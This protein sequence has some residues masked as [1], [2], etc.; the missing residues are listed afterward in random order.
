ML[1]NPQI[2]PTTWT[3]SHM[4][5]LSN[6]QSLPLRT[7]LANA[8][9]A[10]L[11]ANIRL[12]RRLQAKT[13]IEDGKTCLS[14]LRHVKTLDPH[15]KVAIRPF[16]LHLPYIPIILEELEAYNQILFMK[17][18]KMKI[19]WIV[20]AFLLFTA[21]QMPGQFH[22]LVGQKESDAFAL[23]DRI[24]FMDNHLP[25]SLRVP[26]MRKYDDRLILDNNSEIMPTVQDPDVIRMHTAS[27]IF[28]DE[29]GFQK[30]NREMLIAAKPTIDGGG[31]IIAVTTAPPRNRSQK[32]ISVQIY[33]NE[34]I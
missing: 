1:S 5:S 17:S 19:T 6:L 30:Y 20:C 9:D 10:D 11:R 29:Y 31:Q 15:E 16:P 14:W 28:F 26:K 7:L 23:R 24:I 18:R 3:P 22:M 2:Q 4:Q 8:S 12:M 32:N 27:K 34:V 21:R 25:D 13:V 33:R